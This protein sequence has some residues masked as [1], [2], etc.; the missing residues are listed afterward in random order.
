MEK[1][2]IKSFVIENNI[3]KIKDRTE[4][5]KILKDCRKTTING[6]Q[7]LFSNYDLSNLDLSNLDFSDLTLENIVFNVFNVCCRE[8]KEIFN[9][10]FK[11]CSM[12]R[13]SFAQC[14]FMRCNFDSYKKIYKNDK[15]EVISEEYHTT[16]ICNVD[17]FFSEFINCRFKNANMNTVDFRYSSLIDCSLGYLHVIYGDFYMTTFRGSTNFVHSIFELCSISYATFENHC[18]AMENIR[19]LIQENYEVYSNI[20]I[21][22]KHWYK[23]N[24]C[25]DFSNLNKA[26]ELGNELDSRIYIAQEAKYVYAIMSG[27]YSGKGLNRDS[28]KAYAKSKKNENLYYRLQMKRDLKMGEYKKFVQHFKGWFDPFISWLFG[29]GFKIGPVLYIVL[30]VIGSFWGFLYFFDHP[31]TWDKGLAYSIC[32]TMGPYFDYIDEINHLFAVLESAVGVLLIGF[33]G[34][35]IANKIRSNA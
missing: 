30:G 1:E 6:Q 18:M 24:P 12:N 35:V 28:N 13:V 27:I 3:R 32:N 22:N 7:N 29:Y 26:E 31:K 11:G 5:E 19:E 2:I 9:V 33:M 21:H 17:F 16:N 20:L 10:N 8:R 14:K 15:M 4:L 34:F 25:A 23:Q